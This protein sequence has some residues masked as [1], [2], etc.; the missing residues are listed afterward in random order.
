MIS[1]KNSEKDNTSIT[2][3]TREGK[4]GCLEQGVSLGK[5]YRT[6]GLGF[7]KGKDDPFRLVFK[8]NFSTSSLFT[9]KRSI[10][11]K[12]LLHIATS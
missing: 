3:K 4:A 12:T 6:K 10:Q 7:N 11:P 2:G 8:Y 1:E 5:S 9:F